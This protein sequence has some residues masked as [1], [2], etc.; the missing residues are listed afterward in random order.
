LLSEMERPQRVY[1]LDALKAIASGMVVLLHV[2]FPLLYQ[3]KG[4]PMSD[5]WAGNIYDSAMRACVP[6]FFMVS[7]CLLL[8]KAEPLTTFFR[9]RI[10]KVLVPLVVWSALYF[11]FG[12][13]KSLTLRSALSLLVTPAYYHLWYLYAI[14]GIY[15]FLPLLRILVRYASQVELRYFVLLWLTAVAF[16][17]LWERA[18]KSTSD[19]DLLSI[20]GFTGYLV[21]G[22][23]LAGV[24]L[25]P[26][27]VR[28]LAPAWIILVTL[29]A[30]GTFFITG[31]VGSFDGLLYGYLSPGV[32]AMSAVAFLLIS[33][34]VRGWKAGEHR[35]TLRI[36]TLLSQAS[37]GVYLVHPAI[38]EALRRLRPWGVSISGQEGNPWLM[39][40][41]TAVLAYG[42]SLMAVS[43]LRQ[44]P[45]VRR[46][47]P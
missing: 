9:K 25:S 45:V 40:P 41:L 22:K 12:G 19:I 30:V 36:I 26:R 16:I 44:I 31:H 38:L 21:L 34:I 23:L 13:E 28:L 10:D 11:A 14:L 39:I 42:L 2:A 33:H 15:L 4:I 17:P 24:R 37:L 29:T 1:Y 46:C 8:D 43:L 3:Y 6:I 27:I 32:I 5:W 7:G 47:V 20:S 35:V 18:T